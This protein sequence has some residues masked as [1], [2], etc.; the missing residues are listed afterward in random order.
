MVEPAGIRRR[1]R[2]PPVAIAGL[3]VVLT[4]CSAGAIGGTATVRPLDPR[5]TYGAFAHP[6]RPADRLPERLQDPVVG[7]P[8][9]VRRVAGWTGAD[10]Y[11]TYSAPATICL[12]VDS[13]PPWGR[14]GGTACSDGQDAVIGMA[15]LLSDDDDVQAIVLVPDGATVAVDRGTF[16]AAGDGVIGVR[17]GTAQEGVAVTLAFADGH[18]SAFELRAH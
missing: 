13:D 4:A 14:F 18:T 17:P 15:M 9:D 6:V 8:A 2:C 11:L 1:R 10:V 7:A 16:I 5:E 12:V 3:A